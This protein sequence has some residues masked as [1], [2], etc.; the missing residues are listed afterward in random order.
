MQK[1][2]V[3]EP[4][5]TMV[6]V[7][8]PDGIETLAVCVDGRY[9]LDRKGAEWDASVILS[10]RPAEN[11]DEKTKMMFFEAARKHESEKET[12]NLYKQIRQDRSNKLNAVTKDRDQSIRKIQEKYGGKDS[13]LSTLNLKARTAAVKASSSAQLMINE[14]KMDHAYRSMMDEYSEQIKV[15]R[16]E[17]Q[18]AVDA[19]SKVQTDDK[20]TGKGFADAFTKSLPLQLKN[21]LKDCHTAYDTESRRLNIWSEKS[22]I[23]YNISVDPSRELTLD[24]AAELALKFT[25]DVIR[26]RSGDQEEDRELKEKYPNMELSRIRLPEGKDSLAVFVDKTYYFDMNGKEWMPDQV[27][28]VPARSDKIP[29]DVKRAFLESARKHEEWKAQGNQESK[30]KEEATDYRKKLE[31]KEFQKE[32]SA[33]GS[34]LLRE[35]YKHNGQTL[36][37]A[38]STAKREWAESRSGTAP[39]KKEKQE[40]KEA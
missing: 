9:C 24:Y 11:V 34:R 12:E 2:D 31:S 27:E 14:R 5:L 20:M 25:S 36:G 10:H 3:K 40:A 17:E 37:S 30:A 13:L 6:R 19:L 21:E 4:D 38:L 32:L 39:E 29:S 23:S 18:D 7:E 33:K 26:S 22:E 1:T 15:L 16:K 8:L 28:A 35:V